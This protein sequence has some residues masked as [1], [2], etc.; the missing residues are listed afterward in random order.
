MEKISFSELVNVQSLQKMAENLYDVSGVSIGIVDADGT[1]LL[2][3]AG[4]I[5][6]RNFIEHIHLLVNV[7]L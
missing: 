6:V 2:K 7:V 1:A 3:L 4:K 5:F